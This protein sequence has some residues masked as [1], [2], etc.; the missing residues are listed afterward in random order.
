MSYKN[1]K[2]FEKIFEHTLPPS[3]FLLSNRQTV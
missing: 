3:F 2:L 1:K